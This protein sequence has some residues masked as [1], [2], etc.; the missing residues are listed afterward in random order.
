MSKINLKSMFDVL[1]QSLENKKE[2]SGGN[3]LYKEILKFE[4][5]NTYQVRL[6]LNP[7][8]PNESI[9]H[10]YNHGWKSL[11]TGQFVTAMCLITVQKD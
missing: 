1:K 11:S 4:P 7:A 3:G 9:F 5:G 8:A 10:Y 2:T 6:L